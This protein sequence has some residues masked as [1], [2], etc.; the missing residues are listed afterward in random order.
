MK[1]D[2]HIIEWDGKEL[3]IHG[4][5]YEEDKG[6]RDTAPVPAYF[7]FIAIYHNNTDILPLI[8]QD[9]ED[10]IEEKILNIINDE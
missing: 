8:S 1:N 4:S 3:E 6:T 7:N 5:Y 2:F 9:K 10:E